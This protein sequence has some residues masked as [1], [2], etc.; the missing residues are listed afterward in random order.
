MRRRNK[1]KSLHLPVCEGL[2][3]VN[4]T[5]R[6]V[7]ILGRAWMVHFHDG[8]I[9]L[10]DTEMVDGVCE[11]DTQ[12]IRI[13]G[14]LTRDWQRNTLLHEVR[15]AIDVTHSRGHNTDEEACVRASEVG[16]YTVLRDSRNDWFIEF[17][18][19]GREE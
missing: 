14:H 7:W 9:L 18:R 4:G 3:P 1:T 2:E 12:T 11:T 10:N 16:W 5:I 8:R 15:H 17:V 6:Q 19:E 13:A